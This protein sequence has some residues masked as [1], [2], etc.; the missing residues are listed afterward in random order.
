MQAQELQVGQVV[1]Y[2]STTGTEFDAVVDAISDDKVVIV[3]RPTWRPTV[4]T[5]KAESLSI[6]R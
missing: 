6:P 3:Y 5:V 2:T 1:R 4:L